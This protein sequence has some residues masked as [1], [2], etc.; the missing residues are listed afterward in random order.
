MHRNCTWRDVTIDN[1]LLFSLSLPSRPAESYI[2]CTWHARIL[3]TSSYHNFEFT[4]SELKV[5]EFDLI[6]FEVESFYRRNYA[7]EKWMQWG[8]KLSA[9]Y[10][11]P[12]LYVRIFREKLFFSKSLEGYCC[13]KICKISMKN[14]KFLSLTILVL[15]VQ[16]YKKYLVSFSCS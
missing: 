4:F 1:I 11:V 2:K 13:H 12:S 9:V 7:K 5:E 10:S 8:N 16:R 14:Q 3:S 6:W 15:K